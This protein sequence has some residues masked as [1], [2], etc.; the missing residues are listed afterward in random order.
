MATRPCAWACGRCTVCPKPPPAAS[1]PPARTHP[2]TTTEDLALRAALDAGDLKALAAADALAA[3]AQATAASRCGTPRP[4]TA[5]PSCCA[6]RPPTKTGWPARSRGGRSHRAR[7]RRHRPHAAPPPAGAAAPA[8]GRAGLRTAAQLR[9][10]P[11]GRLVRACGIVTVRQQPGTAKGVVF[12]TLEDETGTV[13][14][15]VWKALRE[16]FSAATCCTPA[17]WPCRAPG[18]ATKEPAAR[19]AT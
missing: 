6:K 18:S 3:L 8:P 4:C 10:L 1:P 7:L 16:R 19:S 15:I 14:V 5:R 13:N 11:D 9:D 2:F 12:V 17:C